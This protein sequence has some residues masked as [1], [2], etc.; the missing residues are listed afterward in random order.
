VLEQDAHG[1]RLEHRER[2]ALQIVVAQ[3]QLCELIGL[4]DEKL[5]A[6]G[7]CQF[8]AIRQVVEQDLD[9]DFVVRAVHAAGVVD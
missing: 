3:D 9:V 2:L 6:L 1:A 8:S 7:K 4:V 5:V